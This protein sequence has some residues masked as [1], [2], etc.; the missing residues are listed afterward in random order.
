[1]IVALPSESLKVM[2]TLPKLAPPLP[3][4]KILIFELSSTKRI[5][6]RTDG[7]IVAWPLGET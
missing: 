5:F 2:V 4:D 1:M 6:V 7:E 3:G